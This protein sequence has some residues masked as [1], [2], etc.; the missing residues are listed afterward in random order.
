[1]DDRDA[2]SFAEVWP[3]L[4]DQRRELIVQELQDLAEDNVELDFDRA[5]VVG[6][7]DANPNV[8]RLALEGL[9][10][11]EG[12]D[13]L[14]P[15]LHMLRND[16]DA[17][18][19]A[20]AATALGRYVLQAEFERLREGDAARVTEALGQTVTDPTEPSEV[21]GRAL[22]S[23]GARSEDWV[24]DLIDEAFDSDDRRLR[25]SAVHAMGRS[26]DSSWLSAIYNEL[27][28]E[29]AEMR[30]EAAGALGSI[31]DPEALPYILPLLQDED[32]EVQE[33]AIFAL[34]QFGGEEGKD[35]LTEL[36]ASADERI[37]AAID[38]A[39]AEIDFAEDPLNVPLP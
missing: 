38:A 2:A 31:A 27:E 37:H 9:W 14:E 6:L 13:L 12:R 11:H 8:R 16:E 32:P 4:T 21:R 36:R 28:S 10:E 23:L 5:F 22:E 30:F 34:G 39:L 19:R 25:L 1:M 3:E 15:L 20:A 7:R 29:D 18:V 24:R 26:C 33:A 17:A 35:A